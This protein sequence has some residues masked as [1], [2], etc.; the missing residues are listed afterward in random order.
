MA[1]TPK[2]DPEAQK[3][4]DAVTD[5]TSNP[6]VQGAVDKVKPL[7]PAKGR[8]VIY[9]VGFWVGIV[10]TVAVSVAGALTGNAALFAADAGTILLSVSN[11]LARLNLSDD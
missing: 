10:G 2:V 7:I 5:I 4:S 11:G 9:T 6:D 3:V 8:G 1:N